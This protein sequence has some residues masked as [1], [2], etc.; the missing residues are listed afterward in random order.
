MNVEP[1]IRALV[2]LRPTADGGR[3]APAYSGYR[4]IHKVEEGV[5]AEGLHTYLDDGFILPGASSPTLITFLAPEHY[6]NCLWVGKA[7]TVQE[8]SRVIGHAE[9]LEIYNDLLLD[10]TRQVSRG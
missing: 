8:G 4:P 10:K 7:L 3:R 2:T 6:P 9:V 1:D 5:N